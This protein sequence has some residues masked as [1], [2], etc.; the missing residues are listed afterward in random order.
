MGLV[1]NEVFPGVLQGQV[2]RDLLANGIFSR[3]LEQGSIEEII[4][5]DPPIA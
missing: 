3:L 2:L 5:D 1:E 4:V